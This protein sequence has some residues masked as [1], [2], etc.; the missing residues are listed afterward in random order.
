MFE[1]DWQYIIP[2]GTWQGGIK[3]LNSLSWHLRWNEKDGRWV[4]WSGD[5]LLFSARTEKELEAFILGMTIGLAVL[6]QNIIDQIKD[7]TE[8]L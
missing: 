1:S 3:Y 6:P 7:L 8:E 5:R 4:L 2:E